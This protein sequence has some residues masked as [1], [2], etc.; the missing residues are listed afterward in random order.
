MLEKATPIAV[1][2]KAEGYPYIRYT[3][4]GKGGSVLVS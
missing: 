3:T 4:I 2:S 1:S